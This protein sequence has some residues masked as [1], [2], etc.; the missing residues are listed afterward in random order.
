MIQL[1]AIYCAIYVIALGITVATVTIKRVRHQNKCYRKAG[2]KSLVRAAR[3][4]AI[5]R[6]S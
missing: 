2:I 4:R 1:F 6:Y 5:A 3:L